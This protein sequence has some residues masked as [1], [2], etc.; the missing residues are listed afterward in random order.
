MLLLKER[1]YKLRI[2]KTTLEEIVSDL[3]YLL[4]PDSV[5]NQIGWFVLDIN[6]SGYRI[7]RVVNSEGG[8]RDLTPRENG[9]E[10][11]AYVSGIINGIRIAQ[12]ELISL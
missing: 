1:R 12:A 4:Y 9:K 7:C 11:Y 10:I 8:Q 5:K 2:T 3:N 6:Q